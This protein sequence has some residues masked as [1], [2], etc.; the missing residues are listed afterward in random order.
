[1]KINIEHIFTHQESS[2]AA[3]FFTHRRARRSSRWRHVQVCK[4]ALAAILGVEKRELAGSR[5]YI[6]FHTITQSMCRCRHQKWPG[7]IQFRTERH[8]YEG[9]GSRS[10]GSTRGAVLVASRGLKCAH[11]GCRNTRGFVRGARHAA[12]LGRAKV[13]RHALN[14]D[15]LLIRFASVLGVT[16][17]GGLVPTLETSSLMF[18]MADQ[19]DSSRVRVMPTPEM[20]WQDPVPH[21]A[22]P[23]RR[24]AKSVVGEHKRA[25]YLSPVVV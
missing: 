23:A 5:E 18:S 3:P 21:W 16:V 13:A 17:V 2:P 7:R 20:A 4:G 1:M 14:L 8:P 15:G 12:A 10:L 24:L 22:S 9:N 11:G 6:S 19:L 25:Q